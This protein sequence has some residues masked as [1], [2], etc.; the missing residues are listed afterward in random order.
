MAALL[1]FTCV[2]VAIAIALAVAEPVVTRNVRSIMANGLVA[3]AL[4]VIGGV[5]G[6]ICVV[7]C[8]TRW[9]V[10]RKWK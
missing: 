5:V 2:G 4:G 7:T 10:G 8:T 9:E 3:L 1:Q 6:L